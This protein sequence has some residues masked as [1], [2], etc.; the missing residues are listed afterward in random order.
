MKKWLLAVLLPPLLSAC[1]NSEE[2]ARTLLNHAI[3]DWDRGEL[4][5]ALQ[6]FDRIEDQYL[7]T[8]AATDALTER[9]ARIEGY[10]LEFGPE[11]N[12]RRNRG[13]VSRDVLQ[14]LWLRW[15]HH[16]LPI[17]ARHHL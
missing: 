11:A 5:L 4:A 16:G 1:S 17:S 2:E 14:H 7:H 13:L 12:Q 8:A 3:Q 9:A 10:R 15:H 6:A